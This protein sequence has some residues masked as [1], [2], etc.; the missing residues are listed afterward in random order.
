MQFV[1]IP[2][3]SN[4]H[5]IQEITKLQQFSAV[6]RSLVFLNCG[7]MHDLTEQWF[8]KSANCSAYLIDYHRPFHHNNLIDPCRQIYIVDDG[9]KSFVEA[10]TEEDIKIF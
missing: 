1:I 9:C 2:V 8:Y 3:L 4:S 10:P 5:L 6:I 7:G